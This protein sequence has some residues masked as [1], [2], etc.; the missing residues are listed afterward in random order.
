ML[1]QQGLGLA[2]GKVLHAESSVS[3]DGPVGGPGVGRF[4]GSVCPSVGAGKEGRQGAAR[5]RN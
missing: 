5:G 4:D 1:G 2:R 3:V